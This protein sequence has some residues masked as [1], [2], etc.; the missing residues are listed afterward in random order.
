MLE[1]KGRIPK[2]PQELVV[3]R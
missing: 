3:S 1:E 2:D